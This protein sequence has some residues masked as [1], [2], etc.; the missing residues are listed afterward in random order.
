MIAEATARLDCGGLEADQAALV[1]TYAGDEV[2]LAL[3]ERVAGAAAR[4]AEAP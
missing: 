3:I 2:A 1:E 4:E